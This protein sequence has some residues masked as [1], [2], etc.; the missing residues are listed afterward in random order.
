MSEDDGLKTVA[1]NNADGHSGNADT[2]SGSD[3]SGNADSSKVVFSGEQQGKVQQLI[4]DAYTKAYSKSKSEGAA[5]VDRLNAQVKSLED[6]KKTEGKTDGKKT[7]ASD[8]Q[9]QAIVEEMN[10]KREEDAKGFKAT[11]DSMKNSQVQTDLLMAIAKHN[12]INAGDVAVLMRGNVELGEDGSLVIKNDNGTPMIDLDNGGVPISVDTFVTNWLKARPNHLRS[13]MSQG[14][15]STGSFG[16]DSAGKPDLS[17]L[18]TVRTM[19]IE[20][21]KKEL[22]NGIEVTGS[23]GQVYKFK[24]V[25]NPFVEARRAKHKT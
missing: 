2:G 6:G 25:K 20:D 1:A 24:D 23:H 17:N 18:E 10:Q 8:E 21:L 11:I 14:G 4:N 3:G 15:G 19:P 13:S 7:G 16:G 22:A 5:E 12:V 9:I